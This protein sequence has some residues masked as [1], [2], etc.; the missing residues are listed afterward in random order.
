MLFLETIPISYSIG[1][2]SGIILIIFSWRFAIFNRSQM[3]ILY[4]IPSLVVTGPKFSGKTSFIKN[5][6]NDN[7]PSFSIDKEI[8]MYYLEDQ[9]NKIQ[10]LEFPVNTNENKMKKIRGM[11]LNSIA[12]IFDASQ[13]SETIEN[14]MTEFESV[15]KMF[16]NVPTIIIANKIDVA[17]KQKLDG[18]K[19]KFEKIHEISCMEN[20]KTVD[21]YVLLKN[22]IEDLAK[23]SK[24]LKSDNEISNNLESKNPVPK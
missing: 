6:T 4:K 2:I 18:L 9:N 5:I 7:V 8:A 1:I 17:D 22:E 13:N 3:Q 19:A 23:L 11:N 12:Y 10:L 16:E 15:K 20:K 24:D 14:Q 21:E